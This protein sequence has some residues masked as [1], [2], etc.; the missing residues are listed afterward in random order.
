ME[1][2]KLS[3][4][5]DLYRLRMRDYRIIYQ[6]QDRILSILHYE[7]RASERCLSLSIAALNKYYF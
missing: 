2:V 6:I 5:E 3:D 7:N 1:V 4:E